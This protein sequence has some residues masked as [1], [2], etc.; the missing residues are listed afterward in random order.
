[1]WGSGFIVRGY[2]RWGVDLL[3]AAAVD[4]V[5][6]AEQVGWFEELSAVLGR[7]GFDLTVSELPAEDSA[8]LPSDWRPD[9]LMVAEVLGAPKSFVHMTKLPAADRAWLV[10][11]L[12]VRGMVAE[13]IADRTHCSL[14]L[15]R[16][17]RSWEM[18]Q[19]CRW[20]HEQTAVLEAEL[21][22]ERSQH[23]HT[24][25]ELAG[26][27]RDVDRFRV[28]VDQLVAK[29]RADEPIR[30]CYRGHH[31]GEGSVYRSG[32]REY[33]RECNRE[34]TVAYRKRKRQSSGQRRHS[35]G[36]S[37]KVHGDLIASAS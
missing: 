23:S 25:R 1:M 13:E 6:T 7:A 28:Q 18:T 33:C 35:V 8:G 12:S 14:R 21:S 36:V 27:R 3:T 19:V 11:G 34:N 5:L 29:L 4:G 17:I 15:I 2:G 31:L 26:V 32:G 16:T 9:E 20:V 22:G 10:A 30:K 37:S 24:R